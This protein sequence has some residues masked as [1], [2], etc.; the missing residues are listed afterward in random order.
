[1]QHSL[2]NYVYLYYSFSAGIMFMESVFFAA[3]SDR[4]TKTVTLRSAALVLKNNNLILEKKKN[5]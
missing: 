2:N 4:A 1:M 5:L 3:H